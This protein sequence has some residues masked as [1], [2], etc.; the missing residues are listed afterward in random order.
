GHQ[1]PSS[2]SRRGSIGVILQVRGLSKTFAERTVLDGID[3][4]LRRGDH[5]ALVGPN[6]AGKSSLLNIL[7]GQLAPDAGDVQIAPRATIGYVKQ[8]Q[9]FPR[10]ATIWSEACRAAGRF[11]QLIAESEALADAVAS[12]TDPQVRNQQLQ[13][14]DRLQAEIQQCDAY[15]WQV[16]VERVL[17]GMGFPVDLWHAPIERLSGGQRNRLL[18]A[19][20]LIGQP[21]LLILDEPS[22]H[23]DVETTEWL[24]QALAASSSAVLVV[25]HDRYFLDCV[26]TSVW[27]LLDGSIDRFVGNYSA[28]V[29]QKAMRLEVQRRTFDKQREEVEKLEDF[30]RRHHAGQ[31]STQAEDRRKKLERIELVD[32][33]REIH[34]PRFRFPEATR[35]GDI[36]LRCDKAA[37][38][39][40]AHSLFSR[41]SF[42]ILR[43][44][45]W[46]ILG[47]NGAGKTTLLKCLLGKEPLD[48][49]AVELGANVR[50]G[51]FDQLL[52]QLDLTTTPLE[53]IRVSHADRNDL[54]RRNMLARF[55]IAGELASKPLG[56]LS[57]G[58]RNRTMLALLASLDANFLILDEPTNHLD[59]WSREALEQAICEFS[60]TVLLVTHDR[61]LV[62]ATAQHVLVLRGGQASI[63][64]GNYEDYRHWIKE[65][66]AIEDRGAAWGDR[67]KGSGGAA[68]GAAAGRKSS[69]SKWAA[70][71]ENAQGS[72]PA[73]RKRKFPY[74][75]PQVL[76]KEILATEEAI[77]AAHIDMT[78]PDQL[79]DGAAM[80][81]LVARMEEL[82][83]KLEQLYLHYEEA[84]EL[85]E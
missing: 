13:R 65:G 38:A 57:G 21:D 34:T 52:Q 30:I 28:Y 66:L 72:S 44:Q 17:M 45:R 41:L 7:T 24:E 1:G 68:N 14:L 25:S 47:S 83:Q 50:V 23:L 80:K 67:T 20:V 82:E 11:S 63:V 22:N 75:K 71:S 4:E 58:E 48:Q 3:L 46:A 35:T 73:A 49:G 56:Q 85:N 43:G 19:C 16:Q 9:E 27:E 12:S 81:R 78:D 29:Q 74:C 51:Y 37:K 8:H 76:E 53:A 54:E 39:F 62:N 2:A 6:G 42:Q 64:Q 84:L 32:A 31:K 69:D 15:Q 59:L 60:G 77:A 5:V 18:L 36:V 70:K 26:A 55:G 33:P 40:G 10:G 79:R 61:Y